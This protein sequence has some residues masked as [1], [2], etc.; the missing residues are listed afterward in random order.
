M[1]RW[2]LIVLPNRFRTD[3]KYFNKCKKQFLDIGSKL[4]KGPF[5]LDKFNEELIDKLIFYVFRIPNDKIPLRK[6]VFLHGPAGT[7]KT[8]LMKILEDIMIN[9]WNCVLRI[10]NSQEVIDFYKFQDKQ[11]INF[12]A[13]R[14]IICLDDVGFKE[15]NIIIFGNPSN[16][17]QEIL[18]KRHEK[19]KLTFIVS[20][21]GIDKLMELYNDDEN[22][23]A[24]RL[25]VMFT[26]LKLLGGSRR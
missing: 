11:F 9:E 12:R 17:I 13:V 2:E 4:V 7:G 20:N 14:G 18:F 5:I 6:G 3:K 21:Y 24:D 15:Q 19:E 26:D 25:S 1:R 23:I 10:Y 8:L 22:R 16:P